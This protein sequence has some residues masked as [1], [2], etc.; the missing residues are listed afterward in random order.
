MLLKMLFVLLAGVHL[1]IF[2]SSVTVS[3]LA[4]MLPAN[5][6]LLFFTEETVGLCASFVMGTNIPCR[7]GDEI[8]RLFYT[9]DQSRT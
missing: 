4:D 3:F 2:S 6:V 8:T 7:H 1:N 9:C 5:H